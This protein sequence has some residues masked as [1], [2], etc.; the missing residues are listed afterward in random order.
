MSSR[1]SPPVSALLV[2][3]RSLACALPLEHVIETLRPLAVHRVA[4]APPSVL[5]LSIV[6]GA[7]VPVVDL[8]GLLGGSGLAA[9]A[10]FVTVR[11]GARTAALAVEAVLGVRAL[12]ASLV[13]RLPPLLQ[14]DGAAGVE[15]MLTLDAELVLVLR[16]ARLVP[17]EAWRLVETR[18]TG[19]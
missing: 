5:G 2:R 13:E 11:A 7:A 18:E 10:R 12:D 1:P 8:G 15:S 16:A 6:R 19:A 14:T 17:E 4:G 9:L 3:A